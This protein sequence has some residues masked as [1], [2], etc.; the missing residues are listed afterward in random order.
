MVALMAD[1]IDVLQA[2]GDRERLRIINMLAAHKGGACLCELV[3]ALRLPQHQVSQHLRVLRRVGLVVF[4]KQGAWSYYTLPSPL[5]PLAEKVL[6][7]VALYFENEA[8]AEDRSRLD[9]RLRLRSGD[10]CVIGYEPGRPFRD[11][12]P[13]VEI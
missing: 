13:V 2:F 5:P 1:A 7:G 4:Q 6:L 8:T 11:D 10:V 9:R 12:I 3:D